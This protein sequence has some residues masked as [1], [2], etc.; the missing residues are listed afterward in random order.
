[1]HSEISKPSFVHKEIDLKWICLVVE[2]R[3]REQRRKAGS[4][5]KYPSHQGLVEN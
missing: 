2:Q 3:I 4:T 5:K 1:M